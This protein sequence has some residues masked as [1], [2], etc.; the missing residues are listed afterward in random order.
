MINALAQS[1][2]GEYIDKVLGAEKVFSYYLGIPIENTKLVCSPLRKDKNPTCSFYNKGGKLYFHDFGIAK[3]YSPI[4]VVMAKFD[5]TYQQAC[6][7]IRQDE[8]LIKEHEVKIKMRPPLNLDV[9]YDEWNSHY[10]AY[11]S[12]FGIQEDTLRKYQVSP[13]RTVYN[14]EELYMRGTKQNPIYAYRFPSGRVKLYRPLSPVKDKKWR[15]NSSLEDV[16]G[17]RQL[18]TKGTVVFITSSLKDVM[19][20][21]ELGF[22]A[23]AFNSEALGFSGESKKL[24]TSIIDS[25]R[26]R[27]RFIIFFMNSDEPGMVDNFKLSAAHKLPFITTKVGGPKDISD[28]VK[29]YSVHHAFKLMKKQICKRVRT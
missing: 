20:L 22:P 25:L 13:V 4:S 28:Y 8:L 5:C 21:Y 11:W 3:S 6:E 19:V 2:M 27:F 16:S 24:M 14:N 29:K 1:N 17:L 18:P 23:L 26:K 10:L 7:R 9:V 12:L 15:G